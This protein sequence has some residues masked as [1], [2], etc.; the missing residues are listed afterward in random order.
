[1]DVAGR[2][3]FIFGM[4][5]TYVSETPLFFWL[6]VATNYAQKALSQ[7]LVATYFFKTPNWAEFN[8][9]R[10][11]ATGIFEFWG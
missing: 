2:T 8:K 3:D 10:L 5:I 11:P 1:M 4:G 7:W 6:L 9:M